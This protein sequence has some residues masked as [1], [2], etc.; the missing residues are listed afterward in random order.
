VPRTRAPLGL[1]VFLARKSLGQDRVITAL[2]I[3]A[4]AAGVAFQIPN[5]GNIAGYHD[6]IL[7]Q[8]VGAAFGDVRI[9]P[10]R[11]QYLD[12]VDRLAGE[13]RRGGDV[14]AA[15]PLLIQ[16]GAAGTRDHGFRNCLVV[17][18]D[19]TAERRPYLILRGGDLG[20][21]D[22]DGVVLGQN[23]ANRIG[24]A[25]GDAVQL[26]VI[27]GDALEGG[28]DIGRYTMT[29]RGIAIGSFVAPAA[30]MV[31]RGF[32]AGELGRPGAATMIAV[33]TD[34]HGGAAAL[35]ERIAAAHPV[36]AIPWQRDEPF[37]HAAVI[38]SGTIGALSHTMIALAVLI[39]VW[40]LLHI[41]VLHRR[42]QIALLA[43]AG[44]GRATV[45]LVFLTQA[46]LI[47][48]VGGAIGSAGGWVLVRWFTGHPIF[49]MEGFSIVPVV[50]VRTFA[51]PLLLVF[52]ATVLA[53]VLPAWRAS[54]VEPARVLRGVE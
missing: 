35:A 45:F 38:S 12:D 2:M 23:V 26:R 13:L 47:G 14:T 4:V 29:V 18:V 25:P 33:H 44:F 48:L 7:E 11:G 21:G 17:G 3:V 46:A 32:L 30:V 15:V 1:L 20:P 9:R 16:A 54:R 36:D 41:H 43:A 52:G 27:L 22:R 8:G 31:D 37:V 19:A 51:V 24:A 10:R 39:P 50:D 42:R 28:A 40:A 6:M 49:E 53:G 5:T 34:D